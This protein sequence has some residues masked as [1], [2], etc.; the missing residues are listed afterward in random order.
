[1]IDYFIKFCCIQICSLPFVFFSDSK[2]TPILIGTLLAICYG[3]EINRDIV[4][5]QLSME[6]LLTFLKSSKVG[7][8]QA[9]NSFSASKI[10]KEIKDSSKKEKTKVT[11]RSKNNDKKDL[12]TQHS[13]QQMFLP[14][15]FFGPSKSM[16]F[17]EKNNTLLPS[18]STPKAIRCGKM[19]YCNIIQNSTVSSSHM[20]CSRSCKSLNSFDGTNVSTANVTSINIISPRLL[21]KNV[22][23]N[24]ALNNDI[25]QPLPI[26]FALRNRFPEGL[27]SYAQDFFSSTTWM[28]QLV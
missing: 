27:W 15:S 3:S 12:N 21:N 7:L 11:K 2:L 25:I 18:P 14:N 20:Q 10:K 16:L 1:M 24:D 23:T 22:V 9:S 17:L 8:F 4:Q 26:A 13:T 19:N 6:M 28:R 5:Q